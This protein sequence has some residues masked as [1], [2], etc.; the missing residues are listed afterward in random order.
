MLGKFFLS[1]IWKAVRS[2]VITSVTAAIVTITSNPEY[3]A[4]VPLITALSGA[5]RKKYPGK[6]DWLP[7]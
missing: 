2:A 7:V 5:L 4:V 1:Q 3:A 6:F